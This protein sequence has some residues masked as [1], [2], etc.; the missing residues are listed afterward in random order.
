MIS[1]T[2]D[3]KSDAEDKIVDYFNTRAEAKGLRGPVRVR[4]AF[5]DMTPGGTMLYLYASGGEKCYLSSGA[6]SRRWSLDGLPA[7]MRSTLRPESRLRA[8]EHLDFVAPRT[9]NAVTTSWC[10][11]KRWLCTDV[12]SRVVVA[13]EADDVAD[14]DGWRTGPPYAVVECVFDET[15]Q[16]GCRLTAEDV[17][18]DGVI[19]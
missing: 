5:V 2:F 19:R 7:V 17:D 6:G 14:K 15:D 10:G 3:Y 1:E 16:Q 12:G 9:S 8:E 4:R 11:A 18:D 13:I